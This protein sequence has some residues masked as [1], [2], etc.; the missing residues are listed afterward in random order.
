[1]SHN[2]FHKYESNCYYHI[3]NHASGEKDLFCEQQDFFVFTEKFE[4]YFSNIFDIIAYCLMPNHFHFV[5]KV[6][7]EEF[8]R[9]S[10]HKDADSVAK[11][12]YLQEIIDLNA[13][14]EDQYRRLFSGYSM[15]YN[16]KYKTSGQLFLNRHKRI[17]I[18]ADSRLE[19]SVCYV[20]H[21]P[22]HHK[23]R[24][25][26]GEWQYCSYQKYLNSDDPNY[27]DL[28]RFGGLDLFLTI[29]QD[30]KIE[31]SAEVLNIDANIST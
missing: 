3:Y 30:F 12:K 22:I 9:E 20:H 24:K 26:Y 11:E 27:G 17:Y 31:K 5:V 4:R 15:V 28:S 7:G 6:K 10:I 19:Y 29:H 13:L 23:F 1:M 8:I 18:D 25:N 16:H 2:Y 14:I 21:N